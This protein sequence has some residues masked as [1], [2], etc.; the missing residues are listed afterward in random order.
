VPVNGQD[1]GK[2]ELRRGDVVDLGHVRL[3]FVEA[4]ED[5][6]FW[7]RLAA[8]GVE[9]R[10]VPEVLAYYR[11]TPGSRDDAARGP[12]RADAV[13]RRLLA[14]HG[15]LY[16]AHAPDVVAALFVEVTQLGKSLQRVYANP[17]VRLALRARTVLGKGRS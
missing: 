16:A 6:D 10:A 7:I 5:W 8:R 3:R 17:L 2:V 12:A 13:M 4:G 9:A 1:Y 11:R 14:K 15:A